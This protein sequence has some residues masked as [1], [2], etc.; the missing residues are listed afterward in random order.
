MRL[1]A[2]LALTLDRTSTRTARLFLG[3]A[4]A[5]RLVAAGRRL[6][7]AGCG[8]R[9]FSLFLVA[10]LPLGLAA[11]TT[12]LL[13]RFGCG[14]REVEEVWIFDVETLADQFL[15]RAKFVDFFGRTK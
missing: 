13:F 7:V 14:T 6:G 12:L 10:A 9:A 11:R 5:E 3:F 4:V 8:S 2:T 1:W 15:D